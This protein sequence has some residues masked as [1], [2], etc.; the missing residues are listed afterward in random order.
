MASV[1]CWFEQSNSRKY[2]V[3][4]HFACDG[5][6]CEPEDNRNQQFHCC[7]AY[8]RLHGLFAAKNL[9]ECSYCLSETTSFCLRS[10]K[11]WLL[12]GSWLTMHKCKQ[13]ERSFRDKCAN[14]WKSAHPSTWW[15]CK[16]Y[17]PWALFQGTTVHVDWRGIIAWVIDCGGKPKNL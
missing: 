4:T 10:S 11:L 13:H 16:V 7:Q 5:P 1:L 12:G 6:N 8:W 15:A 2:N 9:A 3:V 14:A 17:H